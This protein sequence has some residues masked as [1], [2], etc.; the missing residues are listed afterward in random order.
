[1]VRVRSRCDYDVFVF[2][3]LEIVVSN[4]HGDRKNWL[5]VHSK[6]DERSQQKEKEEHFH[7][8]VGF[9]KYFVNYLCFCVFHS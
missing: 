2:V 8:V 9:K 4:F 1:M 3:A 6:G 5:A 7:D